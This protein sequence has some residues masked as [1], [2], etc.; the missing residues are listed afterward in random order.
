MMIDPVISGIARGVIAVLLLAAAVYKLRDTAGFRRSIRDYALVNEALVRPLTWVI[1]VAEAVAAATVVFEATRVAGATLAAVLFAVFTLAIGVNLARGR[2]DI[3]CGC[4]GP[5][6]GQQ[7]SGWL[8]PRN[9]MLVALAGVAALPPTGRALGGLDYFTL[10]A[11]VV[12][13]VLVFIVSNVV[14]GLAP[15][16]AALRRKHD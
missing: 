7:L 16:A 2:R 1:P 10:A 3:D 6:Q 12:A 14:I 8:V 15:Q 4:F 9:L 13:F 11:G 5:S